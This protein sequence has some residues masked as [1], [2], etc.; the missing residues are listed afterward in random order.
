[1]AIKVENFTSFTVNGKTYE[2]TFPI[3]SSEIVC[4]TDDAISSE[5]QL[6]KDLEAIS[7]N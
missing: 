1:M 7:E 4:A 3:F 6:K 5:D 2:G